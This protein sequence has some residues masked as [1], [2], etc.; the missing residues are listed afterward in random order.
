MKNLA[1]V[2]V[3]VAS[4]TVPSLSLASAAPDLFGIIPG[5]KMADASKLALDR[6]HATKFVKFTSASGQPAGFVATTDD[7]GNGRSEAFRADMAVSGAVTFLSR[8]VSFTRDAGPPT[9]DLLRDLEAK[10]GHYSG[11]ET[12][13]ASLLVLIW[14]YGKDWQIQGS[15]PKEC[16][17]NT[18]KSDISGRVPIY[19]PPE[20]ARNCDPFMRVAVQNDPARKQVL[21]Y[22]VTIFDEKRMFQETNPPPAH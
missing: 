21:N 5:M 2:L 15:A 11:K 4:A 12:V 18:L 1:A 13:G 16:R 9:D 22:S 19:A 17:A 20:K 6:L 3:A 14:Y 7:L 8:A 10:Y